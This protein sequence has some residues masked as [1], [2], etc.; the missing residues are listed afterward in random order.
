[1]EPEAA[2]PPGV[3]VVVS[4]LG[5]T[6]LEA[7]ERFTALEPTAAPLPSALD[8]GDVIVAVRSAAVGWVDLLMTSGQYQ[9]MAEPPYTPGLEYSGKV[10]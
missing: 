1:M 2:F 10:V 8:P 6:P 3:R 7:V 9:H 4:E 5:D